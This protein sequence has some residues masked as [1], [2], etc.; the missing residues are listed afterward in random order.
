MSFEKNP[1]DTYPVDV[2]KWI[3]LMSLSN[4]TVNIIGSVAYRSLGQY[5][6]IDLLEQMEVSE[7][8]DV[9]TYYDMLV[10]CIKNMISHGA[11]YS[12]IKCGTHEKYKQLK[13]YVGYMVKGSV[14]N[15][16]EVGLKHAIIT[17]STSNNVKDTVNQLFINY[18]NSRS[19]F[20]WETLNE[21]I[22]TLYTIHWTKNEFMNGYKLGHGGEHLILYDYILK[23][24]LKMDM[25]VNLYDNWVEISIM[26]N[27]NKNNVP[28]NYKPLT[29]DEIYKS[30][31][32]NAEK[33]LYSP[34]FNSTY[35]GLKRLWILSRM[36]DD[37]DDG[38]LFS[39]LINSDINNAYIAKSYLESLALIKMNNYIVDLTKPKQNLK[40][41]LSH[42]VSAD[43]NIDALISGIEN[44]KTVDD[45]YNLK[46]SISHIVNFYALQW[47]ETYNVKPII[48][49]YM[50]ICNTYKHSL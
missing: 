48:D 41:L 36:K 4:G 6:D 23:E 32:D 18:V 13:K 7:K 19:I 29:Q 5:A 26:H 33:F 34:L 12:D 27:I 11:L 21:E 8:F 31:S 25:F 1:A 24:S 40:W 17:I 10:V 30:I 46:S 28:I 3:D 47:I 43:M 44:A 2:K 9:W 35:K 14:V 45:F 37:E 22:R 16:D 50:K 49:K 39:S 42:A 38:R 15:F 20:D